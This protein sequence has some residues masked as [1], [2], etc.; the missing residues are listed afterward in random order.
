M[1]SG[2]FWTWRRTSCSSVSELLGIHV[3][4]RATDKVVTGQEKF[5]SYEF[6]TYLLEQRTPPLKGEV[7]L[8]IIIL[9][10][11]W[12]NLQMFGSLVRK[13]LHTTK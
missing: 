7:Y 11:F 5:K 8:K 1:G 9:K 10:T 13:Y 6:C 2:Q 12:P 4:Y 3:K